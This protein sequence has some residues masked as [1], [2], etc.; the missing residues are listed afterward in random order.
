MKKLINFLKKIK[1][2]F[3][4]LLFVPSLL[5]GTG[6]SLFHYGNEHSYV[7][8]GTEKYLDDVKPNYNLDYNTYNV[9]FFPSSG[10]VDYIYD[11]IKNNQIINDKY[12]DGFQDFF[13]SFLKN[14]SSKDNKTTR[15]KRFSY[16]YNQNDLKNLK[17]YGYWANQDDSNSFKYVKKI[18]DTALTQVDFEDVSIPTT[19]AVDEIKYY[20]LFSGWTANIE[21]AFNNGYASDGNYGYLNAFDSLSKIDETVLTDYPYYS[22]DGSILKSNTIFVYPIYT[23]G[24]DYEKD[25]QPTVR[26]HDDAVCD[27]ID[28]NGKAATYFQ[29]EYYFSQTSPTY[30]TSSYYYY[31]LEVKENSTFFLDVAPIRFGT[32]SSDK[33]MP[34]GKSSWTG[35]WWNFEYPKPSRPTNSSTFIETTDENGDTIKKPNYKALFAGSSST[36]DAVIKGEGFYNIY[37]YIEYQNTLDKSIIDYDKKSDEYESITKEKNALILNQDPLYDDHSTNNMDIKETGWYGVFVKVERVDEIKLASGDLK[38]GMEYNNC[39]PMFKLGTGNDTD[40]NGNNRLWADYQIDNIQIDGTSSC[41]M[42]EFKNSSGK[43]YGFNSN[44]F[45]FLSRSANFVNTEI[46]SFS[47]A[48][49]VCFNELHVN[50]INFKPVYPSDSVAKINEDPYPIFNNNPYSTDFH[51]TENFPFEFSSNLKKRFFKIT[52]SETRYYN[53]VARIF[54]EYVDGLASVSSIEV[55]L[56]PNSDEA[57][58]IWVYDGEQSFDFTYDEDGFIDVNESKTAFIG[59]I[60][61][62]FDKKLTLETIFIPSFGYG[63]VVTVNDLLTYGSEDKKTVTKKLIDHL[64]GYHLPIGDKKL[65]KNYVALLKNV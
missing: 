11:G 29:T 5:I 56:A 38:T 2:P 28:K 65:K 9:Y 37:V 51:Y 54:Y 42:K 63:E 53:I 52:G 60:E 8:R 47:V 19:T 46:K 39:H 20:L 57:V 41:E 7:S 49:A 13:I 10:Y 32:N 26:L 1:Y 64:T 55:A 17:R 21:T 3:L 34:L 62:G 48:D 59:R 6:F 58:S 16:N 61:I 50:D 30:S 24:K 4:F 35:N 36:Y 40:S 45:T 43:I 23:S 12:L 15:E 44:I 14:N 25:S 27:L 22:I 18:S 31:N 33:K